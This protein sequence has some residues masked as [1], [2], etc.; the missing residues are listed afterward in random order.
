MKRE[1]TL[2]LIVLF[3]ACQAVAQQQINAT[4]RVNAAPASQTNAP[5]ATATFTAPKPKFHWL[6]PPEPAQSQEKLQFIEGLDPRAW[7]T[8]AETRTSKSA[9]PSG[10]TH[11]AGLCLLWW[12]SEPRP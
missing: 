1:R 4:S 11:E 9:F 2:F 5:P 7:T 12:G 6:G 10:E 8:V 3:A